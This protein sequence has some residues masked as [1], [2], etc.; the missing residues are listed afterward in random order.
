MTLNAATI[1][2]TGGAGFI[3]SHTTEALLAAGA[4]VVVF[5]NFAAGRRS[6]LP[7]S[8]PALSIVEGDIRD[9]AGVNRAMEK[10]THVLHLAAQI[11]VPLSV[12]DPLNSC[13]HNVVGFVNVLECARQRGVKRLVYASSAAV[14][15]TPRELPLTESSPVAPISPYGLEKCIDDQY[16]ALYGE[17]Y[18][19]SSLGMR[20]FNVY[21]PR[22]DPSSQ[23]AGVI[24]KFAAAI[25]A[26]DTLRVFGDGGQTRDFVFVRDIAR[27]NLRALEADATGFCNIGSGTS[28]TLLALIAAL[29]RVAKRNARRQFDPPVTGDIRHSAMLPDR[30]FAWLGEQP[31][32]PLD[33]GLAALLREAQ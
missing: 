25:A 11:S 12:Q 21:G 7:A 27:M 29:E 15:G 5:D 24:S 6:S 2:V 9:L 18:G 31:A 4:N 20:Y 22:Q 17:L 26:G 33:A 8:H 3:G 28:V 30:Q 10:A 32:T 14:Y 16:A 1:L 13:H 19:L 23:Y